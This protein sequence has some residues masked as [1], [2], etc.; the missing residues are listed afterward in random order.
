LHHALGNA[1]PRCQRWHDEA[2]AALALHGPTLA[3]RRPFVDYAQ[4]VVLKL[5]LTRF[6]GHPEA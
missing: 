2:L 5:E 6:R 1:K 4:R 3:F